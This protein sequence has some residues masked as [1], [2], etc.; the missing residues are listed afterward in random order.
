M[1]SFITWIYQYWTKLFF[2][3]YNTFFS[4]SYFHFLFDYEV[5]IEFKII[6]VS[7]A[8]CFEFEILVQYLHTFIEH[9][10]QLSVFV[11]FAHRAC[12]PTSAKMFF[13]TGYRIICVSCSFCICEKITRDFIE[14]NNDNVDF[15]A[16]SESLFSFVASSKVVDD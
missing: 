16:R 4:S 13:P 15:Y 11:Q 8:R 2:S 10:T 9:R 1:L 3:F 14:M 12:H 6:A 7:R 5:V